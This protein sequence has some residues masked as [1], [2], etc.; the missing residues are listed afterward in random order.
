MA[1]KIN[2]GMNS[3]GFPQD[4]GITPNELLIRDAKANGLNVVINQ[5]I[6]VSG[7]EISGGYY[8]EDYLDELSN[9]KAAKAYDVMRRKDSQAQMLVSAVK[10]P[11]MSGLFEI[12]PYDDSPEAEVQSKFIEHL[13]SD[14]D[15]SLSQTK[16]EI[17]DLVVYGFTAM[18]RVHKVS[19]K[20][21]DI[22][23]KVIFPSYVGLAELRWINPKSIETWNFDKDT[24]KLKSISQFVTGDLAKQVDIPAEFLSIFTINKEGD[25]YTGI[26]LLRACYGCYFRKNNYQKLNS[27]GIEKFAIGIPIGTIPQGDENSNSRVAFEKALRD[28]CTHQ[29]NYLIKTEG[30]EVDVKFNAFDP[31]KIEVAIDNEDKRM[32]KSFLASFLELGL[33]TGGSQALSSDLSTFFRNSLEYIVDIIES[34]FN[35]VIIPEMIKLN[36]PDAKK[37]PIL[38]ISGVT[39]QAG[40]ELANSLSAM[41]NSRILTTD[42]DLEDYVRKM[43]SLPEKGD[44]PNAAPPMPNMNQALKAFREKLKK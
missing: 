39:D 13:L 2:D 17:L 32:A 38:Y 11:I 14:I 41:V 28:F 26:S 23:G 1:N 34:E 15:N 9:A 3:L 36:F 43:Y 6:G 5:G 7:T 42:T 22:D 20:P 8:S 29:S 25:N 24:K 19:T 35:R 30:Y 12:R 27:I 4:K 40:A 33:T 18:E 44:T 37:F 16:N 10:L 21:F 31:Q